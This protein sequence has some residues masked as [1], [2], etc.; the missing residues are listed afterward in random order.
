[1]R[2]D[3]RVTFEMPTPALDEGGVR[4]LVS[5][6]LAG[7]AA[8]SA[9]AVGVVFTDDATVHALNREYRGID[10]PTDVL[11]FG[12]S[13]EAGS[14]GD[15]G[16]TAFALPPD[17]GVPLGEV[18]VSVETAHR[19]AAAHGRDLAHELAHLVVH[20]VLHLLGH[21]HAAPEEEARMRAREDAALAACGFPPGTAGWDADH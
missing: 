4:S 1:M 21:D 2:Y 12:L 19:Q 8:P 13:E 9:A 18:V 20:G 15:A 3:I 10:R 17:S 7:E 16:E 11:S 5:C 14:G 6:A